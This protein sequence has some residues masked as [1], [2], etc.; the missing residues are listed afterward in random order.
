[1]SGT[2]VPVVPVLPTPRIT[3]VTTLMFARQLVIAPGVLISQILMYFAML[4]T[5]QTLIVG[6][7]MLVLKVIVRIVVALGHPLVPVGMAVV[8]VVT[9]IS[10]AGVAVA[11]RPDGD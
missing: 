1:M 9:V 4:P 10:V 7:V 11:A 5:I 3:A 2:L 8:I 6:L